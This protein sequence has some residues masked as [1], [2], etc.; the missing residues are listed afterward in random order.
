MES[1]TTDQLEIAFETHGR[2]TTNMPIML[3]HGFPDDATAWNEV[4]GRLAA[5]GRHAIA[6]HVRGCGPT[7]FLSK[8]TPRSGQVAARARDV[9][10]LMDGL[11]IERAIVV[12]QDWGAAT[13]QALAMLHPQ[14]V[15]K[16]VVLNGHGLL[17]MAV[18]A[19]GKRPS[20]A[21]F[22]AGWYQW[23]FQSAIAEPLLRQD[24]AGLARYLWQQWSPGWRFSE[25]VF[26]AV[27]RSL[28]NPDW[29][30]VVL[31][32]YRPPDA[33]P[34]ADPRDAAAGR[35][36]ATAP[37]ITQPTLNLQGARDGVDL[38]EDTQLG[39]EAFYRGGFRC[40]RLE[41][42]GHFLQRERPDEVAS[43]LL[44]FFDDA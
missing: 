34:H 8:E 18:F 29:V 43:L 3:L 40:A 5:A 31:S 9:V 11:Q 16:L 6:P 24:A 42:C 44:E 32:A 39:Q 20:W 10:H 22:H 28:A 2:R 27:A 4:G 37:A 33:D 26:A 19:Q 17:N 23:L 35:Q 1:I 30:D 12:G 38:F 14:R 15:D 41:G 25:E 21:T 7:R 13:A 36:L